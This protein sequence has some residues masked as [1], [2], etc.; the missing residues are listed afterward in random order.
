MGRKGI[1]NTIPKIVA[2]GLAACLGLT[3]LGTSPILADE[4]G[5]TSSGEATYDAGYSSE[6]LTSNY[7]QVSAKY[8]LPEYKGENL[9]INVEESVADIGNAKLTDEIREYEDGNKVLD[10]EL[11]DTVSITVNVPEDGQYFVLFDYLSYD[12]SILP[13]EMSMLVD[14]ESPFYECRNLELETYYTKDEE[15]SYDRYGNE[16]VTIPNKLIRWEEK[17][18]MDSSYRHSE[19]LALEFTAGEHVFTFTVNEGNFLLG[20]I[21]LVAPFEVEEYTGSEIAAGSELITIQGEDIYEANDSSIHG[22]CEFDTSVYPYETVDTVLNTLDSASFDTAGQ[23]V[24]YQ[25]QVDKAG[26]YYIAMNYRQS[27]KTDFQ[28]FL[29]VRIDG[30]IPNTAFQAYGVDYSTKYKT[31]TLTDEE[32]NNLSV[33]LEEG[34]HTISFTINMDVI[35]NV[36]EQLDI[37]MSGINDLALE[38]TKVA[39]TNSDKYRDLKLSKYIPNLE[40]TLYGYADIL[41]ELEESMLP[42][43]KSD[44]NVAVMSSVIIAA[45]QLISLADNPD[46]IPYR[47]AELSTSANSANRYLAN[48]IDSLIRNNLA[49]DRVYIYQE[50]AQLPKAPNFFQSLWMNIMRFVSSFTDQAYSTSNTDAEHLQVWVS[51]STQ[52]VEVMQKMIDEQFTPAT[53]IE[54][55]ISIM[56]DQY[57]L[58]LSNA[59][60]NA[61]DVATGINYTVPY[62]L[63]IRGALVDMTQFE[64]FREAAADYEPGFFLTG[65]IGDSIYSMP[66]TM[67]FWVLYY[68]TDVL[69]KLGLEV[70]K[71]MQDVIDMLPELQM[72]GLDFYYPASGMLAMR[73]FHGTTPLVVQNGGSLYYETAELGTALGEE[74]AIKGFTALTD[75]FTIYDMPNNIDNYYQHFRNGDMPIGIA[76]YNMYNMLTN[77]A[78]ELDGSWEIAVAPGTLQEDGTINAATCGCAESTVIFK[79]DSDR[80]A[81][82]WE[83][84]KWWSSAEVQATFGQTMQITYGD[85]YMWPTANTKAFAQLPWDTDHKEVILEFMANVVDV[86]RI[87]GTY[88]LEREMSN[89]FNDIVV[90]GDNEQ[91]R[92]D[93]AVKTINREIERKLEEFGYIDSEGNVLKEY[94][95]PTIESVKEILGRED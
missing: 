42:Y 32:G 6:R 54:V 93:E 4:T 58:V 74:E 48:T 8:T 16:V 12:E 77:A 37:I 81:Q 17:Y 41:Y 59:S 24:T 87:P 95:I 11:N 92:I 65:T 1:K 25:F 86:A 50:D 44:K 53:G 49:I 71:T 57:K 62:E 80:E 69:E 63:A 10:M 38:I 94:K 83:F 75:L 91:T 60:G 23:Q 27:D 36:M 33:Y 88:L 18:L 40:K 52:Y 28:V 35:R 9:I 19:P 20:N 79:S 5:T 43:S 56:P 51:R 61:P 78:P 3:S 39:G 84:V 46:E 76:D 7:T 13:I 31:S 66:E 34:V 64:D 72:R 67:N 45:E 85:E 90:N 47:I 68:R 15:K 26:Y 82:A 89:A 30:E 21:T 14:G 22:V 73:N 29:D 70:P 2:F 55:D